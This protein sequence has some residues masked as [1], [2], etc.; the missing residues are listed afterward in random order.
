MGKLHRF[1]SV[2]QEFKEFV[3]TQHLFVDLGIEGLK[4]FNK[5]HKNVNLKVLHENQKTDRMV[6]EELCFL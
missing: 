6:E 4:R 1:Q 3:H 2:L 5:K